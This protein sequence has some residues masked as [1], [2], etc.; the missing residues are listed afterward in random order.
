MKY[1]FPLFCFYWFALAKGVMGQS[2]CQDPQALNY[3]PLA[4]QTDTSC[5]YPLSQKNPVTLCNFGTVLNEASS[6]LQTD[7][8][9]FSQNDSGN[10]A[11]IFQI[12]P[13]SS[14]QLVKTT[15]ISNFTNEDWEELAADDLYVYIGDFGNN[16]GNRTNLR[17]LKVRKSVLYH[18]DSLNI[19]VEKLAFSYPDQTVFSSSNTHN[20][21]C[22]AMIFLNGRLH[23]FS[24]NRGNDY[25]KHYSLNP[26]LPVQTAVLHDSLYTGGWITGASVRSDGKVLALLGHEKG[27]SLTVFAWLLFGFPENQ[28]F[29]G[30]RRKI[31]FGNLLSVGQAEGIGFLNQDSL[32]ISNEKQGP[33]PAAIRKVG[34]GEFVS[35]FFLTGNQ[36]LI[37]KE[38]RLIHPNPASASVFIPL[39]EGEAYEIT[40]PGGRILQT[41]NDPLVWLSDFPDGL[42]FV[43]IENPGRGEAKMYKLLKFN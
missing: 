13:G 34:I 28:F 36:N 22:E 2:L 26:S 29:N 8:K 21:D 19:K 1:E 32:L 12:A 40:E 7:G 5:Q 27:G 30:N 3:N 41:G 23:L 9:W 6:M 37:E 4:Q 15:R 33:I 10:P 35:P 24:K 38:I 16:N 43:R 18:P 39:S 25:T 17:I 11:D 42:Y 14:C 31:D 20:F